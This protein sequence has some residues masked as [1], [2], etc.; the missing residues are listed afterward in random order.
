MKQT[1]FLLCTVFPLF[2][3]SA[4]P[5]E[6]QYGA[7]IYFMQDAFER[8]NYRDYF[9]KAFYGSLVRNCEG[10]KGTFAKVTY[11][12][13]RPFRVTP[14]KRYRLS[15]EVFNLGAKDLKNYNPAGPKAPFP[16]TFQFLDD[17]WR[18]VRSI[19]GK[20]IPG[21]TLADLPPAV[22]TARSFVFEAP[23]KAAMF[24]FHIVS[25]WKNNWGPYLLSN[26]KLSEI[27]EK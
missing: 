19:R 1:F 10:R 2:L 11:G 7:R 3:L 21:A 16:S 14:G 5:E 20:D 18:I 24:T 13:S 6:E 15:F 25:A 8:G 9:Q 17:S 27:K 4:A 12:D 22:W 23:P 26:V